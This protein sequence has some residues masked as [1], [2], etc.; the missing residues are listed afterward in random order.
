MDLGEAIRKE[1]SER[2]GDFD[3]KT[4]KALLPIIDPVAAQRALARNR[5]F[6]MVRTETNE[7]KK[8]KVNESIEIIADNMNK[9]ER[10]VYKCVYSTQPFGGI[11]D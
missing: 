7:G 6:E 8:Y 11:W 5:F 4:V 1:L 10:W 9:S 3:E 2:I